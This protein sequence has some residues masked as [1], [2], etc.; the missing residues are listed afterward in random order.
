MI[1][2]SL[3]ISVTVM[4]QSGSVGQTYEEFV[5]FSSSYVQPSPG[6]ENISKKTRYNV[7]AL[8]VSSSLEGEPF[9]KMKDAAKRFCKEMLA[10]EGNNYI[11][12]ISYIGDVKVST[13]FTLQYAKEV[14][15]RSA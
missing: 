1:Y 3:T 10:A 7:L 11:A 15:R 9:D 4:A 12:V 2:F 6:A 5:R 13:N 14:K 8:D